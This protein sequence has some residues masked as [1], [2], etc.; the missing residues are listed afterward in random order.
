M[1]ARRV[2]FNTY[3]LF[4]NWGILQIGIYVINCAKFFSKKT[5]HVL[6]YFLAENESS[7]QRNM[8]LTGKGMK[9]GE[10]H[11]LSKRTI[12]FQEQKDFM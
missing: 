1:R 4:P 3:R 12:F 6:G 2:Y 9:R 7:N 5:H 11:S 10:L 8:D